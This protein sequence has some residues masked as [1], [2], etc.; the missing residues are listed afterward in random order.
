MRA[1]FLLLLAA[2]TV[3][4]ASSEI[5]L[6]EEAAPSFVAWDKVRPSVAELQA[7]P[8]IT[9]EEALQR[10]IDS[11]PD[12]QTASWQVRQGIAAI[13]QGSLVPNPN[14]YV[15]VSD[16][17]G[18]RPYQWF[19]LWELDV[20]L[21][22]QIETAGKRCRRI[23]V[24]TAQSQLDK[25]AWISKA[26]DV[27]QLVTKAYIDLLM[28]QQLLPVEQRLYEL[29][30][31]VVEINKSKQGTPEHA[32]TLGVE[33]VRAEVI[34]IQNRVVYEQA[35][36]RLERAKQALA[37]TWGTT[38]IDFGVAEGALK[39]TPAIP[40]L[41]EV[42]PLIEDNPDIMRWGME[43]N[44]A[45]QQWRQQ[46]ALAVPD[47]FLGAEFEFDRFPRAF[48]WEF[49][50]TFDLPVCNRNQGN[51]AKSVYQIT[52][53]EEEYRS[54]Y[55]MIGTQ[56]ETAQE[57]LA[58]AS[59]VA[60]LL[61]QDAIPRAED[62]FVAARNGFESGTV[63]YLTLI[64]TQ[65]TLSQAE[66]DAIKALGRAHKARADLDRLIGLCVGKIPFR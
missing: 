60:Q 52:K 33:R 51:I 4:A 26:L 37:A 7:G 64:N 59:L 6:L 23:D 19:D 22:K 30:V 44:L 45:Q 31:E 8:T 29:S 17:L 28:A 43:R 9:L 36:T 24:A 5:D 42:L 2:L 11:N 55:T 16:V 41:D 21:T 10:A 40:Q 65:Q 20:Q 14:L 27:C 48:S 38:E 18:S 35:I 58:L 61:N 47:L 57:D 13:W 50:A 53:T 56:L 62:A 49:S 15:A 66:I 25:F 39:P 54:N 32:D 1:F 63:G 34:A 12:L 46:R 3:G